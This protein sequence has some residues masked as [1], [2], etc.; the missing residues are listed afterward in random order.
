MGYLLP[1][2]I[3]KALQKTPAEEPPGVRGSDYLSRIMKHK[4]PCIKE[5]SATA[6]MHTQ[7]FWEEAFVH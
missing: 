3:V 5:R 4:K 7:N 2:R 1:R 6:N